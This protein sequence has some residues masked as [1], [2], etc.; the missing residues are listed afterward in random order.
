MIPPVA[1]CILESNPQ[2]ASLHRHLTT[3]LLHPDGS[4]RASSKAHASVS[5]AL[6]PHLLRTAKEE[7]LRASLRDVAEEDKQ[8]VQLTPSLREVI[9]TASMILDEA[10]RA[11]LS[12]EDH[13]VLETDIDTF[14]NR[15]GDIAVAVSKHLQQQHY[16]LC[17]IAAAPTAPAQESTLT[18]PTAYTKRVTRNTLHTR[19]TI[20]HSS[21][22]S[23]LPALLD[24]LLTAS[25]NPA[26]L[27]SSLRH[28]STTALHHSSV[29]RTLLTTAI[30]H[31]ERIT[32]GLHARHTKAHSAHL[33]AVASGLAKRIEALFLQS[34]NRLYSGEVQRALG[35]YQRHLDT[36][37]DSLK[38]REAVLSGVC[39]EFDEAGLDRAEGGDATDGGN[40]QRRGLMR[41]LG[42]RYGEVLGE[43]EIVKADMERLQKG[44][45]AGKRKGVGR[46]RLEGLSEV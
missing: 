34:R 7:I 41:G 13:N 36:V 14:H 25:S 46:G 27:H 44:V 12:A 6:R 3:N 28:L 45:G 15:I 18:S 43:I 5:A 31:L 11:K 1:Q 24:P 39:E 33:S 22:P 19:P 35:N 29:H 23:S 30:T 40:G 32:L 21:S 10:P 8:V 20:T 26:L 2:F 38:E 9:A 17:K 42:K 16:L 4:T 37:E